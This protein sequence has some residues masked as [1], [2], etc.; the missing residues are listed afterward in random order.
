MRGLRSE[1]RQVAGGVVEVLTADRP[2]RLNAIDGDLLDA[3]TER[4]AEI[5]RDREVRAVIVTG[6]GPRAF[7]AG[8]DVTAF[9]G[10]D[11]VGADA[12]MTRGHRAFAALE[13][14]PQ[15]SIAAINGYALGGGLELALAC[16]FRLIAA[17]ATVGQPE[18]SLASIPGWGATQRLPRIAG[19]AVAKDLILTGRLVDAPEAYR[20]GLVNRVCDDDVLLDE[21][22]ALAE[23][24]AGHAPAPMRLAKRAIHAARGPMSAGL[25]VERQGVGLCF[26]TAE[27]QEAVRRFA[28][29]SAPR[30]HER[31]GPDPT[32]MAAR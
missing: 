17:S 1:R 20:L 10:L 19:E 6:A 4:V 25:D 21:A 30:S 23:R 24:L 2:E 7:S 27:Q 14:L 3:L 26:T 5:G 13:E 9:A 31:T 12:L 32:E 22:L 29:R 18:I 28:G 8:A 15:P 16:D 11:G